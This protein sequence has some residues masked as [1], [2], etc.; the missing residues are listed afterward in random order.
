MTTSVG[1]SIAIQLAAYPKVN[2]LWYNQVKKCE[3]TGM[4]RVEISHIFDPDRTFEH[5]VMANPDR[6][7]IAAKKMIDV[8]MTVLNSEC[9]HLGFKIALSDILERLSTLE[10][11]LLVISPGRRLWCSPKTST[12]STSLALPV[13]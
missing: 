12:N 13:N 4:S 11:N 3:K 8:T 1:S 2:D 5:I 9:K 7:I 6:F 10:H